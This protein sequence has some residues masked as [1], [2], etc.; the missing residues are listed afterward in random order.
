PPQ[1][2]C[3]RP[4]PLGFG[5]PAA[6][7]VALGAANAR[8]PRVSERRTALAG[9][10]PRALVA[11]SQQPSPLVPWPFWPHL[12]LPALP[13]PS[14]WRPHARHVRPDEALRGDASHIE[15]GPHGWFRA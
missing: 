4:L 3:D 10:P 1:L 8:K 7:A 13:W 11:P 6:D 2:S 15:S 5:P 14:H 9:Q 12:V